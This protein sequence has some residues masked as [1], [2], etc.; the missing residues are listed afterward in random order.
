M[1]SM[2]SIKRCAFLILFIFYSSL[3]AQKSQPLADSPELDKV[4]NMV[5]FL[6][7]MLNTLGSEKTS[8]RDKEVL[9][10]ESYA[11]I[12][13]DSKVQI[14]DD[15]DTK[16]D[17]IT[18][19]DVTAYLKDVDFFFKDV[20][21]EF[22]IEN[23]AEGVLPNNN[24][25]YK[26]A[27]LRNLQGTTVDGKPINNTMK[28][29]IEINYNPEDQDLKI[30]S[31]YTNEFDERAALTYWWGQLS[32]EWQ[33]IFKRKL[34]IVDS[35][36]L[37]D[38]KR[39]TGIVTL[40][41]SGNQFI[42]DIGPLSQLYD[43][44]SLNLSETNIT[45]LS[46]IRNLTELTELNLSHTQTMDITPLRY[47]MKLSTLS[48]SYTAVRDLSVIE[49]MP[50]LKVLDL[51]GTQLINYE[52]LRNSF[53]LQRL[54]LE[55]SGISNLQPLD[56]LTL[57]EE[58]NVSHTAVINLNPVAGLRNIKVLVLDSNRVADINALKHL[59]NLSELYI[60][61]TLVSDLSA[62]K[63]LSQLKR[64]YCDHSA[65]KRSTA[66]AF[67]A[68]HPEVLV[69]FDSEDLKSW[70]NALSSDWQ[71]VFQKT[72]GV[73]VNSTKEELAKIAK[74][75]SINLSNSGVMD[76]EPLQ[77]LYRL[78][79]IIASNT[80]VS[81]LLPLQKLTDVT[82][83]DISNTQVN[84]LS[85]IKSLTG[86]EELHAHHTL[87]K[88]LPSGWHT[89]SLKKL[90]MDNSGI[91]NDMV[92]EFLTQN[93]SCLVI[94]KTQRL[95]RWWAEL[96]GDWKVI[97]RVYIGN[98][99]EVS[100]EALHQLIEG[101]RLYFQDKPVVDLSILSEFIRLK[102]LHISGTAI[103]DLEPVTQMNT[104]ESLHVTQSPI[105]EFGNLSR[106][107]LLQ[108]LNFSGTPI[109]DLSI[110]EGISN[111]RKLDCSGTQLKR[112]KGIEK[113]SKLEYL[114]CSN[115]AVRN[116]DD[117]QFLPLKTLKCFNTKISDRKIQEYRTRHPECTV[118][119]YR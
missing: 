79:T 87:I 72:I 3:H 78:K 115:T 23:I 71:K 2:K 95:K 22:T 104:L 49:N 29:F 75:D 97:F 12:F 107:P 6:E 34:N 105:R 25:F 63:G 80:G 19:K 65:V 77:R 108:D 101:E 55:S 103:S 90:D 46:P 83:L 64:I 61:H 117:I 58:L 42:Q 33:S 35:V 99:R 43:L 38:L 52:P 8:V 109:D 114:D 88:S 36:Q 69:I 24:T 113:F 91:D 96:P 39:I 17:V 86:L 89:P 56:S 110:I 82:Y 51:S 41:L 9:V 67:M 45:D 98:E 21:F 16:R 18:N 106:L 111:L 68:A 53:E 37:S 62:L 4:K 14:E 102:E 40:D 11:K 81:D 59:E 74:V 85:A 50:N 5:G 92:R 44:K 31:I 13:R 76:L 57:L 100:T 26:V 112:L 116:I 15:L 60:N 70:W 47:A 7:Y 27:L 10:T 48:L 66:E 119:Y 94:Y 118:V 32:Y 73:S 54:N 20:K 84:D 28:R 30:V 1:C 93:S